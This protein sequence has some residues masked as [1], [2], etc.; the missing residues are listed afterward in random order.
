MVGW[1][2]IAGL[3]WKKYEGSFQPAL[4]DPDPQIRAQWERMPHAGEIPTPEE[5]LRYVVERLIA[6]GR[7]DL[8]TLR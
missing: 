8:L 3:R 4:N 1:L 5:L 2:V 6:D 7:E